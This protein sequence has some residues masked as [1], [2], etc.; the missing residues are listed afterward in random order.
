VIFT[1]AILV[2]SVAYV[3]RCRGDLDRLTAGNKPSP[4]TG[5][6][7]FV[8]SGFQPIEVILIDLHGGESN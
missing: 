6:A 7:S 4:Q 1:A 5:P 2:H 8:G 3:G